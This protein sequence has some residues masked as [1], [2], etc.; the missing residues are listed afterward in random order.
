MIY[1]YALVILGILFI[2]AECGCDNILSRSRGMD[3]EYKKKRMIPGY[4]LIQ[5]L[6]LYAE[7]KKKDVNGTE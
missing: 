6:K 4:S 2:G 3:P 1:I 7:R 5:F